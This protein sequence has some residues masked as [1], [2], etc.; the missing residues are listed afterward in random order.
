MG[1]VKFK[2]L[3]LHLSDQHEYMIA[4]SPCYEANIGA[5]ATEASL[6][7]GFYFYAHHGLIMNHC[8]SD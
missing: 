7:N 2:Q 5:E 4:T 8:E 3:K 6:I 1:K